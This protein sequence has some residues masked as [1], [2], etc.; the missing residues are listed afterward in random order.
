ME[1][2]QPDLTLI[3]F[4]LCVKA[5]QARNDMIQR[6]RGKPN[7][8]T[9]WYKDKGIKVCQR[10]IDTAD[11]FF[12]D[13]GLPPSLSHSLD[14][15]NSNGDYEPSNCRWATAEEQTNNRGCCIF[16]E[17]DG[18]RM[19]A[20]QWARFLNVSKDALTS[21]LD[22][23]WSVYQTL[24]KPFKKYRPRKKAEPRLS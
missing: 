14:R 5:W 19:T 3:T 12:L 21:R 20:P 18:K 17:H 10:W 6:C 11:N 8:K 2:D 1:S 13:M 9:K 22:R 7:H 24:T 4:K 23:G 16:L 15:I